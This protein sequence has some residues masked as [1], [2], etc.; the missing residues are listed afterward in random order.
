MYIFIILALFR[1]A[2]VGQVRWFWGGYGFSV[3]VSCAYAPWWHAAVQY[4]IAQQSVPAPMPII[5]EWQPQD[6]ALL[7]ERATISIKFTQITSIRVSQ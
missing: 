4:G 1:G 3:W 7:L 2:A 6:G 5:Y